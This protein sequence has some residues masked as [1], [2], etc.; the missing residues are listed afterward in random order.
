MRSGRHSHRLTLCIPR[1]H[2]SSRPFFCSRASDLSLSHTLRGT[3]RIV[4]HQLSLR[5]HYTMSLR[6]VVFDSRW[7][8]TVR[9]LET[10]THTHY[11]L[12]SPAVQCFNLPSQFNRP[13]RVVSA[14]LASGDC[15]GHGSSR[16]VWRQCGRIIASPCPD[17][18]ADYASVLSGVPSEGW[19]SMGGLLGLSGPYSSRKICAFVLC[20]PR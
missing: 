20:V 6:R 19:L 14:D 11:D 16:Q 13:H 17:G 5:T 12:G 15:Q 1:V 9:T 2:T 10:H 4:S 18:S 7:V 3:L 8:M